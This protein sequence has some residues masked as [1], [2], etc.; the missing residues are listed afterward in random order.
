MNQKQSE[1]T[2]AVWL[3]RNNLGLEISVD[4]SQGLIISPE[5]ER[6][7]DISIYPP[8]RGN[9]GR[10]DFEEVKTFWMKL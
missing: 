9:S 1:N 5:P 8:Y 3:D 4:N 6:P 2:S 7:G 10:L